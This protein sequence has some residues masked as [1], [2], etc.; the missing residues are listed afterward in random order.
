MDILQQLTGWFQNPQNVINALT[1]VVL[2]WTA[3]ETAKAR[4][5]SNEA[6][7]IKL[8][9]LLVIRFEGKF[10]KNVQFYIE[11]IGEGVAY[12]IKIKPWKSYFGAEGKKWECLEMRSKVK[13]TNALAKG[14]KAQLHVVAYKDGKTTEFQEGLKEFLTFMMTPSTDM[15]LTGGSINLRIEFK[16]AYSKTYFT[17]IATGSGGT[18]ILQPAIRLIWK[19]RL[20]WHIKIKWLQIHA[21]YRQYRRSVK[22]KKLGWRYPIG[23]IKRLPYWYLSDYTAIMV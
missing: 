11:N 9:P 3:I 22:D 2:V 10:L 8:L 12:N 4:R 7:E 16:N 14:E 20:Y 21:G 15:A 1:I 5:S 23:V 13:G 17:V 6:N 18:E 19:N